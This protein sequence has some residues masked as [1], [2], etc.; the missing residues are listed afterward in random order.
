MYAISFDMTISN[1]KENYGDPYNN[2]YFE[3]ATVMEKYGFYRGQGSVYLS[4]KNDMA[5]LLRV[6]NALKN[7]VWFKNSVRDIRAF[8]V[9]D[10]SDFTSFIKED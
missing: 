5:N 1:L 6:I 9:E 3:I 7:I 2:A 10:W 4:T 8:R